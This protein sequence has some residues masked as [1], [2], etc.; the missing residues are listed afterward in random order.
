M[1]RAAE[2]EHPRGPALEDRAHGFALQISNVLPPRDTAGDA[3]SA[4]I[5]SRADVEAKLT[6]IWMEVLG[7]E[8][9]ARNQ[10]FFDMGGES[11]QAVQL[12]TQMGREFNTALNS[13]LVF[14]ARTIELQADFLLKAQK[15]NTSF[16]SPFL[17]SPTFSSLVA[18]QA[19]GNKSAFFFL[20]TLTGTAGYCRQFLRHL[21]T[22]QPVYGLHSRALAG[23][24]PDLSIE[25][26][27]RHYISEMKAV[28]ERGP[29]NLF[30]YCSGGLLAFEIARQLAQQGE[31]IALLA[32]LNTP[33]PG[34]SPVGLFEKFSHMRLRIEIAVR[35][36]QYFGLG[37]KLAFVAHKA[38]NVRQ[39]FLKNRHR[40]R[41]AP[42]GLNLEFI[43]ATASKMY[44]PATVFAGRI[45]F[46]S[47]VESSYLYSVP[48]IEGWRSLA[49]EGIEQIDLPENSMDALDDNQVAL[50][51]ERM[52][53]RL[54]GNS[55][56]S[57]FTETYQNLSNG[58]GS[59]SAP[60]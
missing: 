24:P 5:G 15:Q 7:A 38:K 47:T 3:H 45:V 57:N 12:V 11:V 27:A 16:S 50:V 6:A 8:S 54:R 33:A 41:P 23:E 43:N 19:S 30:G 51:V 20:H 26:M 13:S 28:Q 4:I 18:V 31:Q 35:K 36:L 2:S 17:S 1:T 40:K 55:P 60:Q 53:H 25:A 9:I 42:P 58:A 32:M 14:E 49:T 34:S 39:R 10:D 56:L 22:D 52:L 37:G 46:F 59:Q 21:G 44:Q 48:P 29:Y